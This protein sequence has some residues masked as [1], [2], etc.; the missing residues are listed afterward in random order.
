[1]KYIIKTIL[2]I[3]TNKHKPYKS[4]FCIMPFLLLGCKKESKE[5]LE[6]QKK[7]LFTEISSEHSGVNF[8]NKLVENEDFHYYQYIYSYNGSGVATADFNNDGLQDLF[9]VSNLNEN[10]LYVNQGNLVFK[11][12]TSTSGIKTIEGFKTG[13]SIVDINNDGF[14]DIYI[15]RAGWFKEAKKRTNLLYIN[16]GDL[17]FTEQAKVYGLDDSNRSMQATFFDFDNDNDLDLYV[18]N[19]PI[20]TKKSRQIINMRDI[21][22]DSTTIKLGGSDKLYEN[23]GNA[24]YVNITG[25]AGIAPDIAFGLNPQVGDLNNDGWLD[26]YVNNDF[27]MPDFAYINN[28]NGTFSDQR[29]HMFKHQS[30]YSMGGDIVDLNNDGFDDLLALDMSPEDYIRSKT[31]MSMSSIHK[32]TQMV[33]K[34]Y[35]YQYMHNV[36]QMNNKNGTFS[37]IAHLSGIANTDWSW[38]PL[39]ADF[40][41]DGHKDIFITN[42]VFRDVINKD[43]N[44]SILK[45]LR[46]KKRK[47]SKKDFLKYTRMLPQQKLNNYFFKNNKDLTFS[48]VTSKWLKQ[49][50]TF[51]N[52]AVY[53]DLDNDG[54]LDI[55][56]NNINE[57]AS[58]LRN[59]AAN[60][61]AKNFIKISFEGP[62]NNINGLG[63]R[64]HLVFDDKSTQTRQLINS[65]GY[66][67]SV[68]NTLHF[69]LG[70][71]KIIQKIKVLWPDG[72]TQELHT[73]SS[74]KP[75]KITY[76]NATKKEQALVKTVDTKK[77]FKEDAF[78]YR[79]KDSLYNDYQLQQ[80]LPHKLS[81][82]GPAV[83]KADINNDGIDDVYLGGGYLQSGQ[84]L[85]GNNSGAFKPLVV[86]DFFNDKAHED[87]G[88]L[89]F[90]ADQDGDLDL[91]VV[92][93]SYEFPI[94]SKLLQDR[95]YLNNKNTFS[96]CTSCL[97]DFRVA[98]SMVVP[99]DYDNDGDIDLFIGGRLISEKYP[100]SPK[101]QLLIN[102]KGVFKIATPN[103]APE[104]EKTGMV[105]DAVW[106][107]MDKDG[108]SDLVVTGEWMGIE[109][110]ENTNGYL[111][112]SIKYPELSETK[113][114]WNCLKI[115]DYD[116]D[117]D[118][119]IIAGNL[120]LNYSN[121]ASKEKPFHNYTKDFD[122]N[123]IQDVFLVKYYNDAQV[124]VRGKSCS[125]E[126]IPS[127]KQKIKT[128]NEFAS[129]DI[130]SILGKEINNALHLTATEFRSGIFELEESGHYTFKPFTNE[131]QKS[132][133]NSILYDDFNGDLKKDL[134]MAGNN[135]QS[136]IETTRFDAGTGHLLLANGE[137]AFNY[138]PSFESGFF[139]NKDVRHLINLK[140][141]K[142]NK[143]LVIN[144]NERHTLFSYGNN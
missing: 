9:F 10:K 48:D 113:G 103:L 16:N 144:N 78:P 59:D 70:D 126:Q 93:G 50:P 89:F 26:I 127:L 20:S 33:N 109:V 41:L 104:L 129:M 6:K 114:W 55:V 44:A 132:P 24:K 28:R 67:S 47:P 118:L 73:I 77:W 125:S 32:F 136:E 45:E 110:F 105:T 61:S 30:F 66:L 119:D 1:M 88:A 141:N 68:S 18:A 115:L 36:L 72:K 130:N 84:L 122:N 107:D 60:N 34:G 27:D 39:V 102:T 142:D 128:Y 106:V 137:G 94:G 92:S 43:V 108:D 37:E 87:I 15:C 82:L 134:L 98:G 124:P 143:V 76:Q 91:Y 135:Y 8:V 53:S 139:A 100:Y 57:K 86:K 35:H 3:V 140:F 38:T 19:A 79:H 58:I 25:K 131:I 4:F 46:K 123:G 71:K 65:R 21:K 81:Q 117:G 69:G 29:E 64:V 49:K 75:L 31:T 54:D 12:R 62:Q 112:K 11:D 17:T 56:I 63:V 133:I 121:K 85:L 101:S 116:K 23:K 51:S 90:D 111:K 80:L 52:G 14:L 95:L 97:P 99:S 40:D 83:A 2:S 5:L 42:G 7:T 138:A 22:N 120:G 74:N 13:V 96:R